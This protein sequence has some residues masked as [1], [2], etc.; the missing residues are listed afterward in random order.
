MGLILRICQG[1]NLHNGHHN[2][3][4]NVLWLPLSD[5][6]MRAGVTCFAL[7]CNPYYCI[8]DLESNNNQLLATSARTHLERLILFVKYI[9]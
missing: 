7:L 9:Q 5:I 1:S 3:I 6:A 8:V 2:T 4:Y